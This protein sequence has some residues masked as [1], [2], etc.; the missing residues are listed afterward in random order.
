MTD[1]ARITNNHFALGYL[2]ALTFARGKTHHSSYLSMT[3]QQSQS[4]DASIQSILQVNGTPYPPTSKQGK[5]ESDHA[6]QINSHGAELDPEL[7]PTIIMADR[8]K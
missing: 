5:K 6:V 7:L 2:N 8:Q 3:A 1:S 4:D